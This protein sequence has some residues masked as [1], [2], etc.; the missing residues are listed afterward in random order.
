MWNKQTN[1]Q[2][3]NRIVKIVLNNKRTS[4]GISIPDLKIYYRA[5]VLKTAWNIGSVTGR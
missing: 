2:T 3:K 4:R 1:K 5:I